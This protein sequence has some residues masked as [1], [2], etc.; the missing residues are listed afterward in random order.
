MTR[1]SNCPGTHT[2][3]PIVLKD[4]M[5]QFEA[6]KLE[7]LTPLEEIVAPVSVEH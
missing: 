3:T 5:E 2:H 4:E 6:L 7:A 1:G